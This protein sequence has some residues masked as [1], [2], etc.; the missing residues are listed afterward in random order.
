MVKV[1][2]SG[3]QVELEKSGSSVTA[4]IISGRIP[5]HPRYGDL[6]AAAWWLELMTDTPVAAEDIGDA[7]RRSQEDG[8]VTVQTT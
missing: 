6:E 8:M 7:L 2:I 5:E 3:C 1:V 4:N